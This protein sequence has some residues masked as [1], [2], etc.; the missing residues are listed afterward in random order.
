MIVPW[1]RG[2]MG[3]SQAPLTW[4]LI[5][6]NVLIFILTQDSA[7]GARTPQLDEEFIRQ[8]GLQYWSF[9][10][11]SN[12]PSKIEGVSELPSQVGASTVND[13]HT[14]RGLGLL[15]PQEQIRWGAMGLHDLKF[16]RHLSQLQ[17]QG[18]VLQFEQWK[19]KLQQFQRSILVQNLSTF[20]FKSEV[21][22][23]LSSITYQFM[24]AGWLHLLGNLLLILIV[25]AA[26]E[27]K[28][29]SLGFVVVHLLS[30]VGAALI[31]QAISLPSPAPMVGAS[32]ALSGLIGF[33]WVAEIKKRVSFFYFM[34]PFPG[35]HGWI[36][37]PSFF[38]L[39]L[40]FTSD[41]ASFLSASPELGWGV[42]YGAH[43]G[44]LATGISLALIS[45]AGISLAS[46]FR[47][48]VASK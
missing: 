17:P 45:V 18:D 6:L 46:R 28:I 9:R 19:L 10:Q 20:G 26:L 16:H 27:Q 5:V 2:L 33:Y 35:H 11:L 22:D 43:L 13:E 32:G 41:V 21:W 47:G 14:G 29:G 44:G 24:H 1:L 34:S 15:S 36:Y 7:R 3:F 48:Q 30:G 12:P 25:G 23:R 42:A 40:C 8:T 38:L 31:F 39:P 37:L 4:T